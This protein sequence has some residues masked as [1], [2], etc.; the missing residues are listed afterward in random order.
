MGNNC[1]SC[2]KNIGKKLK[3]FNNEEEGELKVQT[4]TRKFNHNNLS[5]IIEDAYESQLS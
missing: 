4:T 2:C 1:E 5:M 3:S